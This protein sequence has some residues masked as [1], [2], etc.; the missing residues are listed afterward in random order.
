MCAAVL[1]FIGWLTAYAQLNEN[2]V[3]SVLNRTVQ[4]KSDGTWLL[5]NVPANF[6]P[7][8]A[9]AT[10]VENGMTR[11]GQSELFT[12]PA[13]G[14]VN[15]P[16]IILGPVIPIPT[17]LVLSAPVTTLTQAF[18]TVPLTVIGKYVDGSQQNLTTAGTGTRYSVT[19]SNL[20]HV[21]ADGIVTA[22]AS[23]I[24]V[25]QAQHEG[26]QGLLQ[27]NVVLSGDSDGDGIPDD[28][29]LREGLNPNDP[30]DSLDDA[31]HDGLNNREEVF[32]GT[33]LRN[34]DTDG[35]TISDG[36]EVTAGRDGYITN[37]LLA[38][39]DGDGIPDNVEIA[40]GSDPTNPSSTNLAAALKKITVAPAVFII[41]VNSIQGQASQQLTVTG[42]FKLGG[43]IN[44]TSRL[45]GTNYVSD[46]LSSCNFGAEDGRVYGSA[47]G[48]CTITVSNSGFTATANG[49]VTNV[50][51]V[52]LSFIAIPGYPNAVDVSGNFAYVAAGAAGLQVVQIADRSNPAIV[53]SLDTPGNANDVKIA[54]NFAYIADGSSGLQ[55]VN[56]AN[57]LAPVLAA[58]FF[59]S[60]E[61]WDVVVRGARAYI[62]N[63]ASGLVILDV[64]NPAAPFLLG[65]V[66]LGGVAKG[67]DIDVFR[68]IAVVA[69]GTLGLRVVDVSN[70][71]G[72]LVIGTLAGGDVRD[73]AV[74]NTYAFLADFNRSFTS[75]NLADPMNPVITSSTPLNTGGRLV[76]LAMTGGFAAG[77]GVFFVNGVPLIDVSAPQSPVPRAILSFANYRDD[78]GT[79][80]A[81]DG[82]YVYLTA[83]KTLGE[84]IATGD[85]RL[86]IGKYLVVEDIGGIPPVVSIVSP[87]SGSSAVN[88]DPL[89]IKAQATDDVAVASVDFLVNG[90]VVFTDT[91][92][93][94]EVDVFVSAASSLT[95]GA[96]ATD[97]AGNI[98]TAVP[99]LVNVIPDPLT[100]AAGTV[101][102]ASGGPIAGAA[103]TCLGMNGST[104][105]NGAFSIFGISTIAGPLRC[106][107]SIVL[108]GKTLTGRSDAVPAVRGGIT[109]IGNIIVAAATNKGRD[110]WIAAQDYAAPIMLLRILSDTVTPVSITGP[111]L[112]SNL[113]SVGPPGAT[114]SLPPLLTVNSNQVVEN[115]AIHITSNADVV[116]FFEAVAGNS[117]SEYVAIPTSELGT[118][119]F[120]AAYQARSGFYSEFLVVASQNN[121]T[122]TIVPRCASIGGSPAG[123]PIQV[124]LSQ[125]QTYQY[126]CANP[127]D[128]TGSR[129]TS[130]KPVGVIAGSDCANLPGAPS[131]ACAAQIP[132]RDSISEMMLPVATLYGT[133]FYS[134]PLPQTTGSD[135]VRVLAARNN[136][137]V[138]ATQGATQMTFTLNQ[139]EFREFLNAPATRYTSAQP[140]SVIQYASGSTPGDSLEI[141]TIPVSAFN[142]QSF[143]FW[144]EGEGTTHKYAIVIA[145]NAAVSSITLDGAPVTGFVPLPGGLYQQAIVGLVTSIHLMTASQ[146]ISVLYLSRG[147]NSKTAIGYGSLAGF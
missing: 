46:N 115:K 25:V 68:R 143:R 133:E 137:T 61:A 14:S 146:P 36:E 6:G 90:Q 85:G 9:R 111:G 135:I 131:N 145:P 62:A 34:P 86:Y 124:L 12:L 109:S 126:R 87:P 79:G 50:T 8:R 29:E 2:C 125:G 20:V 42:E 55:I 43:T 5:P 53:A 30:T 23:G 116:V 84:N 7:V 49:T 112:T 81:M 1:Q 121:T 52:P 58:T 76:D 63:G 98:G 47:S 13:G 127:G 88:G 74:Q 89:S 11:T 128:V 95:I 107:A 91:S 71:A 18:Q 33:A 45:R 54:G 70:P 114:V 56:I 122:V 17:T 69:L 92:F 10:C 129:I 101:T 118:E 132:E 136:T 108:N 75:V 104:N 140:F 139:G 16:K 141:Q 37:P 67:V 41:N 26:A 93:P 31:D 99:V 59:T 32:Y 40:S 78:E 77:A 35:D 60:G 22:R 97:F 110:F 117:R 102:N 113:P 103:V 134:V 72:P 15:V 64:S 38:D 105:A 28:V 100:T 21:S 144:V 39:T 48:S 4:V 83:G 19:N 82:R 44:L 106:S 80:I 3:V 73:V 120:A 119:Y 65:S 147:D 130:D 27:I 123:V 142:N 66:A 51:P 138:T 96:R 57:P 24:V 94:Y